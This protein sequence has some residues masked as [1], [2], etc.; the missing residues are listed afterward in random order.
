M[1][2]PQY[3]VYPSIHSFGQDKNER[4]AAT[5]RALKTRILELS[6]STSSS[7]RSTSSEAEGNHDEMEEIVVEE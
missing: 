3:L 2:I 6:T 4:Q 5:I 1:A 7:G